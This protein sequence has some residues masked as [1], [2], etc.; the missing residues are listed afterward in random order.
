[1]GS[2][3]T[4][5]RTHHYQKEGVHRT[6]ITRM[7]ID[8]AKPV[9]QLHGVEERGH[10]VLRRRISRTQRC[11][12]FAQLRPCLV[13]IE[14]CGS[15]HHGARTLATW[16]HDVRLIAP[17]F[18]APYRKNDK[19]DGNDAEAIGE[20]VGRP[21]MRCVP[22]K[23]VG[24]QAVLTVHRARQLLVA[25]RTALVTQ[26]RGWLAEYGLIVSTGGG[27]LRRALPE[28]LESPELPTMARDVFADLADRLRALDE[29]IAR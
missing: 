4:T 22:V 12:F 5:V 19:H 24:P 13:G 8:V 28:L 16:G 1:M 21:H 17:Q 25:E 18:V 9:F 2:T 15:A 23:D 6:Q 20:A 26:T 10:T 7:G 3:G 27:V 29:R 11:P 14:A